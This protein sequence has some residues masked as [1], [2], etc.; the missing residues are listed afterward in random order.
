MAVPNANAS[1]LPATTGRETIV[2]DLKNF[3]AASFGF[4]CASFLVSM[5]SRF[6][7]C[8]RVFAADA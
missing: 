8:V 3:I 2:A 7:I 1:R 5:A 6:S 4:V